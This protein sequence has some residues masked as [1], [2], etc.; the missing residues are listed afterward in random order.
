M[1]KTKVVIIG[2]SHGGHQSILELLK[3][4]DDVDIK[5][6]E[7]GDFVSFMSCGTELYLENS[8]TDVNDV[9]NFRPSDF[10]E[11]KNVEILNNHQV[12]KIDADKKTITAVDTK[13]NTNA[14]YEYDKLI[15]SPGVNPKSIPVPGNDLENV[16]LMR[17]YDWATKIKAKLEDPAVKN[18]TIVGAGYIGIEAAEASK[19]AGKNVT[20]LDVIDRP[21]GTYLDGEMT[22]ILATHLEDKGVKVVTSANIKEYT[23][24]G[25]VTGV[26]TDKAEYPSDLVIQAA[27]VKPNT[28]WLKGT[29]DLDNRGWIKVDEYLQ[30]NLKDVYAIGDATLA[31]SIP[32]DNHVPIALATVARREARYVIK[33]LFEKVP[34]LPF[35]GVV[36]SSA[37]SVFD[38]HFAESGLNSFT[39]K[40]SNVEIKS[41]FYSGDLRPA[42]VPQGKD[43]PK[44]CVQL[45]F[46]PSSHVLLGGA[47]L[48]TYDI[49]A[50]GNVLA[51]AIQHKL[52]VE[53]LADADFFFQPGFDRQWSIL[54][55]AAQHALGE[56]DF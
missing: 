48:S 24:N 44:V 1:S 25:K 38:Y 50:Q 3:R 35:G 49:T 19:K 7:A 34:A 39:A 55:V 40:N 18:V 45:F 27:G 47:V 53:D 9:R 23:G 10:S 36:G 29:V 22:D 8:V 13:N 6:F 51:L 30:T 37:L 16:F 28:D 41:S 43:N 33:H 54:N 2:A 31:Y 46:N 42:Y 32:A 12:T 15:L 5:L 21:L 20:I 52:T 11:N 4:Y 17:G 14:D 26:K 56:T